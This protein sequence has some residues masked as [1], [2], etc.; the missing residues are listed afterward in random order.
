M[1]A[2]GCAI[3][4]NAARNPPQNIFT[5]LPQI[6]LLSI[7]IDRNFKPETSNG[8]PTAVAPFAQ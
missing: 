6:R 1:A 7:F 2:G 8:N 4:M 5:K 3:K